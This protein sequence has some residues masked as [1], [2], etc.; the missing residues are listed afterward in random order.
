MTVEEQEQHTGAVSGRPSQLAILAAIGLGVLVR[1]VH[2]LSADFPLNDGG[3]FYTM[4]RDLQSAHYRLPAFTAYNSADIPFAYPPLAFYIAGVLD[5]VTPLHLLDIFRFLPLTIASLTVLAFFLLA[6]SLLVSKQVVVAA[7]LAFAVLPS[8]FLWLI[9]GGGL[10]RSF[11]FLFAILTLHQVHRFY[12]GHEWRYVASAT[13]LSGLTLLS[14]LG[15]APFVA[16]SIV[17][18]FL[19]FGR[20]Q[21]GVIGSVM[22]ALG[23]LAIAAPWWVTVAA[24]H[25]FHPFLAAKESSGSV[26]DIF[27]EY[28]TIRS[29]VIMLLRL[30]LGYTGEPFFPILLGLALMGALASLTRGWYLLPAWWAVLVV[31]EQ[32]SAPLF[33][34]VPMAMLVGLQ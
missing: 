16:F 15:T 8:S 33:V 28:G 20:H 34:S 11:G 32:R 13:L 14:H 26:L 19:A 25:G 23:T 31:T 29:F 3:M 2:V 10:T 21:R 17:V 30:T 27:K 18:F 7:V 4:V 9:M 5:A 22:I 1:A 12:T 24:Q 6:R